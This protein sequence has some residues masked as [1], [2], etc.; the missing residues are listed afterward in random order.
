MR[1]HEF[2]TIRAAMS[3]LLAVVTAGK[4]LPDQTAF[5]TPYPWLSDG[6]QLQAIAKCIH[7]HKPGIQM[8]DMLPL[9][10]DAAGGAPGI[11]VEIG[12]NDG[13]SDSATLVLERCLNWTGLLIEPHPLNFAKLLRSNRTSTM[14]NATACPNGQV[15]QMSARASP[16]SAVVNF[17]TDQYKSK[18]GSHF[19]PSDQNF[20]VT[21]REM[22]GMMRDSG[23]GHVHF[24]SLDVQGAEEVVL[25]S[26][27][28]DSFSM[29][30]VEAEQTSMEKNHR[31]NKLLLS[32]GFRQLRDHSLIKKPYTNS[33]NEIYVQPS[34]RDRRLSS[35]TSCKPTASLDEIIFNLQ[36]V[37]GGQ[38][39]EEAIPLQNS[40]QK[41][42]H[43]CGANSSPP[44]VEH[45]EGSLRR[46]EINR[47]GENSAHATR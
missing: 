44:P 15:V 22:R 46:S 38:Y 31:V 27:D 20:N 42:R 5:I 37:K 41:A 40:S 13:I 33:Y 17:A 4:P 10:L 6:S 9:V 23:Y 1:K 12:A 2:A 45:R 24:L 47:A 26:A 3:I 16:V 19:G 28:V 39:G 34:V 7:Q 18:W 25:L 36:S 8:V 29:V 30:L 21:C 43:I 14:L 35:K 32:H 11:F